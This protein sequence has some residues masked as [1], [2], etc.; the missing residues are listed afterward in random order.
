MRQLHQPAFSTD[1]FVPALSLHRPWKY[2]EKKLHLSEPERGSDDLDNYQAVV[3]ETNG[4]RR[5]LLIRYDRYPR[6]MVDLFVPEKL[7]CSLKFLNDI[8]HELEVPD[9]AVTFVR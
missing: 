6:D 2:F 4:D 8:L 3:M 5:F 9:E 7:R 1:S